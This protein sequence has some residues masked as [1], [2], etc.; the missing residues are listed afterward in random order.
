MEMKN[1]CLHPDDEIPEYLLNWEE[2]LCKTP[3]ERARFLEIYE[4]SPCYASA[5]MNFRRELFESGQRGIVDFEELKDAWENDKVEKCA[6]ILS[7]M[8]LDCIDYDDVVSY[9]YI[10]SKNGW[11]I[12]DIYKKHLKRP[13]VRFFGL[14][15]VPNRKESASLESTK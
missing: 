10:G 14:I 11:T 4:S 8:S 15:S 3:Q 9:Q 2:L 12:D 5:I 1:C 7:E 13:N 6:E